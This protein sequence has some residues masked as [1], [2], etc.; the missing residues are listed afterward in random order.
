MQEKTYIV[1]GGTG[2][3]GREIVRSLLGLGNVVIFTGRST[4]RGT[5]TAKEFGIDKAVF[6]ALDQSVPDEVLKFSDW[7]AKKNYR[8][9]GLVNNASRNSRFS[10]LDID[11]KEWTD[12]INLVMTSVMI[13]SQ[14]AA[15]N[16][17]KNNIKGKIVNIGAIQ[18]ISPLQSSL[19]YSATKGA[20]VSMSRSM[21]VDLGKYGIQVSSLIPGPVYSKDQEPPE[22]VDRSAATL[23]GRF[24]R[25][26]EV[27][28]LVKFL[29]S[30]DNTFMTGNEIIIDG[31]RIISRKSD[32][33]EVSSGKI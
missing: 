9:D 7:L 27:V 32:P 26:R 19:A 17:I 24:G 10:I 16:M 12:M 30:D 22:N 21:A 4:E 33:D 6:Y 20:L 8:I 13:I 14:A 25:M 18:Y 28:N 29:L 3:I 23:L 31:G 5:E 11:M 2:G 1:T 15:K